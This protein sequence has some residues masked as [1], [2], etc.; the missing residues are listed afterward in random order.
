[1]KKGF[2]ILTLSGISTLEHEFLALMFVD[3]FDWL[4]AAILQAWVIL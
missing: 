3:Y 4:G 1:V 2:D